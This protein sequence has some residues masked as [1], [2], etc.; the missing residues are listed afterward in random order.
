M[1]STRLAAIAKKAEVGVTIA[2]VAHYDNN[3]R[4]WW[5]A[6]CRQDQADQTGAGAIACPRTRRL[7]LDGVGEWARHSAV[8]PNP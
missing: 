4:L 5:A 7:A 6:R 8:S 1:G 2:L 3:S